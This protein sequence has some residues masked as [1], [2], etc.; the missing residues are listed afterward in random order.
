PLVEYYIFKTL[1]AVLPKGPLAVASHFIYSAK[2]EVLKEKDVNW[3][4]GRYHSTSF[5][6]FDAGHMFPLEQPKEAA[7]L[8]KQILEAKSK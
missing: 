7:Q 1:P 4:K 3:L 6:P 5:Y 8:V 2:W